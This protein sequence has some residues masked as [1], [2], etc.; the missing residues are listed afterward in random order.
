M[1]QINLIFTNHRDK[2]HQYDKDKKK[3]DAG[4]FEKNG[5]TCFLDA[6]EMKRR[7]KL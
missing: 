4:D 6:K 7:R 5:L 1:P 3:M 2:K